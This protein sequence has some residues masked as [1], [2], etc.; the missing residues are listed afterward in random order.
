[1]KKYIVFFILLLISQQTLCSNERLQSII[2]GYGLLIAAKE[3]ELQELEAQ[4]NE[5]L[6]MLNEIKLN[7]TE[8]LELAQ[9][10]R[11]LQ[12]KEEILRVCE[13]SLKNQ[14]TSSAFWN[15]LKD[16][17]RPKV[18]KKLSSEK[19]ETNQTTTWEIIK[20]NWR[21][22]PRQIVIY[23]AGNEETTENTP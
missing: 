14:A 4:I 17:V 11:N 8:V 19:V 15:T 23:F 16:V 10:R 21:D 1:M 12:E 7:N 22:I 2:G 6:K 20:N 9:L 5:T 3:Q 13:D 18:D